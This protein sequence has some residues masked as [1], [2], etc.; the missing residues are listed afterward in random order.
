MDRETYLL[1]TLALNW[2]LQKIAYLSECRTLQC[3]YYKSCNELK[4]FDRQKRI[5]ECNVKEAEKML[6]VVKKLR[7]DD[8]GFI[9]ELEESL[10]LFQEKAKKY[11]K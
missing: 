8:E 1:R 3:A 11:Q 4:T 7:S 5:A 2:A 6:E 10:K 9:S